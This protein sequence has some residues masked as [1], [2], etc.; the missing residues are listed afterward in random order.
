MFGYIFK[1]KFSL[2]FI[3]VLFCTKLLTKY[4]WNSGLP[5]I[6]FLKMPKHFSNRSQ[7]TMLIARSTSLFFMFFMRKCLFCGKIEYHTENKICNFM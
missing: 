1:N 6:P 5:P 7:E 2:F 4:K 3:Y